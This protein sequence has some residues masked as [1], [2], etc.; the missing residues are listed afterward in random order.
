MG[1]QFR[2][3]LRILNSLLV[4]FGA[5]SIIVGG[6]SLHF[7]CQNVDHG[8]P[9]NS[10]VGVWAGALVSPNMEKNQWTLDISW[11]FFQQYIH[12]KHSP[13]GVRCWLPVVDLRS[14]QYFTNIASGNG[15]LLDGTKPLPKQLSMSLKL[16]ECQC[17]RFSVIDCD[18]GLQ[19]PQWPSLVQWYDVAY[20]YG[21]V[22]MGAMASQI[23]SITI[24]CSNVYSGADQRK[25][26]SFASLAFVWGIHRW[27]VNSPRKGPV[28]RKMFPFDD[29]II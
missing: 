14:D 27:P 18:D 28:T 17:D 6:L 23:T 16:K 5:I 11:L 25:H 26:Q 22:I 10:G 9:A 20:H 8:W 7:A 2:F 13:L 19:N 24:V 15:L 29:V 21:D 3:S 12:D 4:L 1:E